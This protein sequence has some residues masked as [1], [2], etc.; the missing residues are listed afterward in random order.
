MAALFPNAGDV[1]RLQ[2]ARSYGCRVESAEALDKLFDILGEWGVDPV[3]AR[4]TLQNYDQSVRLGRQDVIL[5]ASTGKG[6]SRPS[7]LVDGDGPFY[8]MEVQPS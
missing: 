8:A 2:R 5:D 3:Q 6:G 7:P 1:D 4:K